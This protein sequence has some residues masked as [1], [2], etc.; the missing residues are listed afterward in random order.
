MYNIFVCMY[1]IYVCIFL[2]MVKLYRAVLIDVYIIL[3]LKI[4]L[5]S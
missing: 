3:N 5:S 1:N 4:F 2:W